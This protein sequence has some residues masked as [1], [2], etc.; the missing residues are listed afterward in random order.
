MALM[1]ILAVIAVAGVLVFQHTH[2]DRAQSSTRKAPPATS[3]TH[4]V[5]SGRADTWRV[6]EMSSG[7]S[8][9]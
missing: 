2:Q 6:R 5:P 4:W 1:A 7:R 3:L 8:V 9:P